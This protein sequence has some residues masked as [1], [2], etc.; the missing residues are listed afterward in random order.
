MGTGV[1]TLNEK[2]REREKFELNPSRSD[3]VSL[4]MLLEFLCIFGLGFIVMMSFWRNDLTNDWGSVM[5]VLWFVFVFVL[6]FKF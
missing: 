3:W 2:L 1:P 4:F 5:V 6:A